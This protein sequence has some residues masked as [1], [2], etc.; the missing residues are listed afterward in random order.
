MEEILSCMFLAVFISCEC[1]RLLAHL[2]C[3]ITAK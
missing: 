1:D 2:P 3:L